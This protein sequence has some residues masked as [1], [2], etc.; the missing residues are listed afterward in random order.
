ML[1]SDVNS[2]M[3]WQK[4]NQKQRQNQKLQKKLKDN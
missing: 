2:H 3:I 1:N 4:P